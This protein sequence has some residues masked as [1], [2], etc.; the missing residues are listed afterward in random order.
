M[1]DE[2]KNDCEMEQRELRIDKRDVREFVCGWGAAVINITITYPLNKVIFRQV[3]FHIQ[4][5]KKMYTT[6]VHGVL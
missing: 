2:S 5:V 3:L 6:I 1:G 4:C